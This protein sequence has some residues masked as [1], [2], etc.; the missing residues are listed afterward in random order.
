MFARLISAA[1]GTFLHVLSLLPLP[2]L[3]GAG[4]AIGAFLWW[5][6]NPARHNAL[7]NL[8]VCM[9][10]LDAP[11]RRRIARRS[12]QELGKTAME[13][14]VFWYAPEAR[15][16]RL[17]REV[18]GQELIA[19]ALAS[20]R[21]VLAVVP[22]LGA[23]ELLPVY[24]ARH[25]QA[26]A[27]YRPPRFSPLEPLIRQVRARTGCR[28]WPA[29]AAGVRG[30]FKVLRR[31]EGLAVLPDQVPADEGVYADFFGCPAKTMTLVP[32]LAQKT[33]AETLMMVAERLPRGRGFRIRVRPAPATIASPDVQA[34]AQAMNEAITD[35]VRRI[36]E[37]YQWTYRRFR[38]LPPGIRSPYRN[39]AQ[40]LEGVEAWK[41]AGR[42]SRDPR[43]P[44]AQHGGRTDKA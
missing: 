42:P 6:P 18:Q 15:L 14:G 23:W 19:S 3:H 7:A 31:G 16:N 37:Q 8:A 25:F 11:E 30:A 28:L 2:V 10:E 4:V 27:M 35:E 9:A 41:A 5:I 1:V 38:R 29:S 20:G 21:G 44:R 12:L 40:F 24:F 39:P 32:K 22:H 17:V 33:G 43:R 36:P 34:A 26:N 13:M